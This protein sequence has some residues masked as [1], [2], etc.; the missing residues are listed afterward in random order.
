M[1]IPVVKGRDFNDRDQHTSTPVV[2]VTEA[3]ARQYFAGEEP[4]GK[5]IKPGISTYD[6]DEPM[7]EIV[8][9]VG[10]IRNRSLSVESNLPTTFHKPRFLL[11][12]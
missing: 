12:K 3:F 5:R 10:N 9:V 8:G 4:V 1:G 6:D 11:A 7:R 2:I